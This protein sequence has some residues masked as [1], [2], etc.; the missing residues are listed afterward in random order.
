MD[1]H[2]SIVTKLDSFQVG[3]FSDLVRA[4]A[5]VGAA[6][7]V[8]AALL[9]LL[10]TFFGLIWLGIL[11]I[12]DFF[13][14]ISPPLFLRPIPVGAARAHLLR[15]L[16]ESG[17]QQAPHYTS[18]PPATCI[19]SSAQTGLSHQ[20]VAPLDACQIGLRQQSFFLQ[21]QT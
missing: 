4:L 19:S 5:L 14:L 18:P 9:V 13:F 7:P 15:L 17:R 21:L 11:F 3:R 8:A 16:L 20:P 12:F 6:M 1:L 10:V 2:K